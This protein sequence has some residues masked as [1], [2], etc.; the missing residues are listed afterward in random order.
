MIWK[1]EDSNHPLVFISSVGD[2][3]LTKDLITLF[4]N[5][6]LFKKIKNKQILI[7][8]GATNGNLFI[9]GYNHSTHETINNA[10]VSVYL[11]EFWEDNTNSL[12]FDDIIIKSLK[13]AFKNDLTDTFKSAF[14]IYYQTEDDSSATKLL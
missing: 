4:S 3:D 10:S 13:K 7:F 6:D 2:N 12:D 14:E 1:D 8:I 11:H 9:S 5:I